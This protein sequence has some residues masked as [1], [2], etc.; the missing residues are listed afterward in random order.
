LDF[1]PT[2]NE[3]PDLHNRLFARDNH[4]MQ[5]VAIIVLAVAAVIFYGIV[6][7]QVTARICIEY[8]TVGHP[9][10]IESDSPTVLAL[11]WGVVATWWVGLPL[12]LGLA[13]AARVGRRPKLKARDLIRPI[14]KLLAFM[15]IVAAVAGLIGFTASKAGVFHLIEPLAS[16]VPSDKHTAFLTDGWAHSGS[17][18]AGIV[19]GLAL[20]LLT[21]R[22]RLA[23][24]PDGEP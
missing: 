12:G 6:Y 10:L 20:W 1:T 14:G 23:V 4:H 17:Y 21:W 19:G 8:F 5:S 2:R 7:D 11:F 24:T 9:R 3:S 15:F 16:R 18:L 13:V 22:R